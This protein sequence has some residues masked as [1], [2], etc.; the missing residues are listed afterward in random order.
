MPHLKFSCVYY[1]SKLSILSVTTSERPNSQLNYFGLFSS[2]RLAGSSGINGGREEGKMPS[3]KKW[4]PSQN[5]AF[6]VS[7]GL[8]M[9]GRYIK[10]FIYMQ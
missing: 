6:T 2:G 4:L 3:V 1:N 8:V 9:K 7:T 10:C 5:I